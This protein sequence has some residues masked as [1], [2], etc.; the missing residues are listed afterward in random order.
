MRNKN[1]ENI[2][3]NQSIDSP[4]DNPLFKNDFQPDSDVPTTAPEPKKKSNTK[5]IIISSLIFLSILLLLASTLITPA[6]KSKTV[7]ESP[8][9]TP[10]NNIPSGLPTQPEKIPT[11]FKDKFNQIDKLLQP[12][13]FPNPPQIDPN[14][15]LQ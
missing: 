12:I 4:Q 3:Q 6:N 13:N 14:I 8:T 5:I 1:L 2:N 10:N 7:S 15:G 9:S 11:Q